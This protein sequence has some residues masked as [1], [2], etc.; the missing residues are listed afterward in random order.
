MKHAPMHIPTFQVFNFGKIKFWENG[1]VC[2][3]QGLPPGCV[4][5]VLPAALRRPQKKHVP[6]FWSM[7]FVYLIV[8]CWFQAPLD[9]FSK[10]WTIWPNDCGSKTRTEILCK[11]TCSFAPNHFPKSDFLGNSRT[12]WT[13]ARMSTGMN[14][15]SP[16]NQWSELELI[17]FT[18][19]NQRVK[20]T[21]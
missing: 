5:S 18:P 9:F 11:K 12:S 4:W 10:K 3:F 19:T 13:L 17:N 1:L 2:R 21:Q 15:G 14:F 16:T 7:Y 8:F 6:G 20:L